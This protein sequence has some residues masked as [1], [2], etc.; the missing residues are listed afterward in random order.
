MKKAI[1]EPS[2]I[3]SVDKD[4]HQIAGLHYNWVKEEYREVS[5]HEALKYFYTQLLTGDS[6]DNIKGVWKCGPVKAAAILAGLE[7]NERAMFNAVR[8]A[9][10]QDDEMKLNGRCLWIYKK[11]DDDWRNHWNQLTSTA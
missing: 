8:E 4:L 11:P 2:I 9:Y 7:G 3:C 5:E 10:G 1:D 6:A